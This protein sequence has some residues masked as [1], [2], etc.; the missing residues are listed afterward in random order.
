MDMEPSPIH[1]IHGAGHDHQSA[2]WIPFQH[3]EPDQGEQIHGQTQSVRAFGKSGKLFAGFWK[4]GSPGSDTD[5]CAVHDFKYSAQSGDTINYVIE[6][7][8]TVTVSHSGRQFQLRPGSII[9]TPK[10]SEVHWKIQGPYFKTFLL[11]WNGSKPAETPL[12]EVQVHH[13]NDLTTDFQDYHYCEPAHGPLV[14]GEL[15][16]LQQS[17]S[18]GIMLSGIWRGGKGIAGSHVD[19][20]GTLS[21]PYTAVLGDETILLLEG[22][23]NIYDKEND[24]LYKFYAGDVIGLTTGPFARKL[25]AI[26][27]D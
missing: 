20:D 10:E 5:S 21:V 6:G 26:T 3:Y 1:V 17:G 15:R 19:S 25:W 12:S 4:I 13:A 14:A 22:E 2:K 11:I 18:R 8:A 24:V 16:Y 27:R 9:I 7:F 23:V